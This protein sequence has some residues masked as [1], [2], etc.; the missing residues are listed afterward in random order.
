[1]ALRAASRVARWGIDLSDAFLQGVRL[2][3]ADASRSN[4][5]STD[6]AVAR[7]SLDA[8]GK[9]FGA[10]NLPEDCRVGPQEGAVFIKDNDPR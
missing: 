10:K 7:H 6:L 9:L 4:F 3:R 8:V 5:G 1:M 2:E